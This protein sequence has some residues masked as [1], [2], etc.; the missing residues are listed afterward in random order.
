MIKYLKRNQIAIQKYDAC[1]EKSIQ[2]KIYAF[3]WYLDCVAHSWGVLVL[4]D[5]EAV[6]PIP[7]KRKYGIKYVTQPFFCQQLGVFSLVETS[8][9]TQRTFINK[10]PRS[11]LKIQTN[12]NSR[13]FLEAP[14]I[15]KTNY[16]LDLNF[17]YDHLF[18]SCNKGRKHA[19]K[20]GG[21]H[22]L[23]LR[24]THID[25]LIKTT[26][27]FYKYGDFSIEDYRRL[28]HLAKVTLV[29]NKGF[30]TGIFK[31]DTFLGGAFFLKDHQRITYLF[32]SFTE[33]G[34]TMQAPSYLINGIIKQHEN[35]SLILDFEGGNI[36]NIESFFR[37]FGAKKEPYY[38]LNKYNI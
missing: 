28:S 4:N 30:V 24:K 13:N 14:M 19:I 23:M 35:S 8:I 1:I 18:K 38:L 27:Q 6:M 31:G 10:I 21:K 25:D 5:Y 33:E 26:K 17:S 32:S 3:S 9:E 12:F 20:V 7:W 29:K 11:F 15:S 2:T 34:K 22:E 16:I 37:S 36:A